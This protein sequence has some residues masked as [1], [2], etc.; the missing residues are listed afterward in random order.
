MSNRTINH[1]IKLEKSVKIILIALAFGV[2]AHAFIPVVKSTSA[3]AELDGFDTINV[4]H[5]GHI[6][7]NGCD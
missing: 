5:S 1:E 6:N 3:L 4:S 7:C 2:I